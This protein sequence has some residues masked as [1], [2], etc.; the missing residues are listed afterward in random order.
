MGPMTTLEM[1][2]QDH[3]GLQYAR[4][5]HVNK[6]KGLS[7]GVY[8]RRIKQKRLWDAS[9]AFCIMVCPVNI[10]IAMCKGE[11]ATEI[12]CFKIQSLLTRIDWQRKKRWKGVETSLFKGEERRNIDG[13]SGIFFRNLFHFKTAILSHSSLRVNNSIWK[14][15][16]RH[17]SR[18]V[19]MISTSWIPFTV[20]PSQSWQSEYTSGFAYKSAWQD[21]GRWQ[22]DCKFKPTQFYEAT[23]M[24]ILPSQPVNQGALSHLFLCK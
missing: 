3:M 13:S 21:K 9:T 20:Y 2:L 4:K 14:R 16:R 11:A 23:K 24:S 15:C 17:M 6:R 22:R 10:Y 12:F 1:L 18:A 19:F 8:K 5:G 7:K